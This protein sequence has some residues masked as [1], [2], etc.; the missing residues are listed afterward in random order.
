MRFAALIA[1]LV[2]STAALGQFELDG[3]WS[4]WSLTNDQD[5][6]LPTI[7]FRWRRL[8]N[9]YRCEL[10]FQNPGATA[11]DFKYELSYGTGVEITTSKKH[12]GGLTGVTG[13]SIGRVTIPECYRVAPS[14]RIDALATPAV[15]PNLDSF[16]GEWTGDFSGFGA[17][18]AFQRDGD[19]LSGTLKYYEW[20]QTMTGRLQ[21]DGT[22]EL[23]RV[24]IRHIN[25]L[26][27]NSVDT[28]V[29]MRLD[30]DGTI[31]GTYMHIPANGRPGNDRDSGLF[32]LA[33]SSM[34]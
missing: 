31:S 4:T 1:L 30:R 7:K 24:S 20:E 3:V 18:A 22:V 19:Q 33:R 9:P 16:I 23:R 25:G 28:V 32:K 21:P 27:S 17:K 13:T 10:E 15:S 6:R 8:V 12:S 26:R 2:S 5:P 11:R 14:V 34:K 29:R